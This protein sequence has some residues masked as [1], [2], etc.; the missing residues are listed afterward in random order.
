MKVKNEIHRTNSVDLCFK[1]EKYQR[2]INVVQESKKLL[3]KF[4]INKIQTKIN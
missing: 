4:D 2:Q 3:F 1:D